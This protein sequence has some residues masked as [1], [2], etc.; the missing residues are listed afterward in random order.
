[1]DS[2]WHT[3]PF[4]RFQT[5]FL[6]HKHHRHHQEWPNEIKMCPFLI[7]V[8]HLLSGESKPSEDTA[9]YGEGEN[10]LSG[11]NSLSYA[12]RFHT[13]RRFLALRT[14][15][16]SR[17]GSSTCFCSY[18]K[19]EHV[20]SASKPACRECGQSWAQSHWKAYRTTL[21]YHSCIPWCAHLNDRFKG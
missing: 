21:L 4:Y 6:A 2:L 18:K 17:L 10:L 5:W 11:R 1:M 19:Q 3:S 7:W 8:V 13:S 9:W 20:K 15:L 14:F 12:I 16:T